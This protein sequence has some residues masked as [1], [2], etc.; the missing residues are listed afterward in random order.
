MRPALITTLVFLAWGHASTAQKL[1]LTPQ[2]GLEKNRTSVSFNDLSSYSPLCR[3]LTPQLGLRL[4]YE[5]KRGH[6]PYL[7][8]GTTRHIITL[9][10]DNPENITRD[11]NAARHAF[12]F[13]SEAG[14]QVSSKPISL[15]GKSNSFASRKT[16]AIEAS[17]RKEC[18][19]SY[20]RSKCGKQPS[21]TVALQ[22]KETI[23][24]EIARVNKN[25]G[26]SMRIQPSAGAAFVPVLKQDVLLNND[27]NGFSYKAGNYEIGIV[28]R[29][30]FEFAKN[31]DAR[32]TLA[33]QYLKGISNMDNRKVAT[34]SG[35]KSHITH[36]QSS[37]SSWSLVAGIPINL[38]KKQQPQKKQVIMQKKVIREYPSKCGQY[39][40]KYRSL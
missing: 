27:I 33:V 26:W 9:D 5:F 38:Y 3:E 6:G 30:G 1:T 29:V 35:T 36:V 4:N 32:F 14:Y 2:T 13:R 31:R 18:G 7:A 15:S 39:K 10:V 28:S 34:S 16:P 19:S 40:L 11:L 22:K 25:K 20:A 37:V 12:K 23:A 21:E 17:P 8:V 24:K